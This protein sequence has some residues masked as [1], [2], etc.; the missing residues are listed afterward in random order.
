[1]AVQRLAKEITFRHDEDTTHSVR[2]IPGHKPQE[3][4]SRMNK[5]LM[6]AQAAVVAPAPSVKIMLTVSEAAQALGISEVYMWRLVGRK[7]I[8]SVKVGRARRILVTAL[9]DYANQLAAAETD[10]A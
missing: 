1:M 9:Q 4:V 10:V 6:T 5:T 8:P 3:G 7:V 2:F